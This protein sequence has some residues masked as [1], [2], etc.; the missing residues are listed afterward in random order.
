MGIFCLTLAVCWTIHPPDKKMEKK[1]HSNRL[2]KEKSP[3]LLQHAH[4][5]VDWYPWGKE[6]FDKARKED[7]PILIKPHPSAKP[8]FRLSLRSWPNKHNID[9]ME[10]NNCVSSHLTMTKKELSFCYA[11][12]MNECKDYL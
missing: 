4:N 5:P 8:K 12:I 3:Y 10:M 2:I 6:A 7:K 1:S 9:L 11:L